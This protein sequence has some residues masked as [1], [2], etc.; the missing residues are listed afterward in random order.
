MYV[1]GIP[2]PSEISEPHER[3]TLGSVLSGTFSSDTHPPGYYILMWAWTRCFGTSLFSIRLPGALFG[4]AC[5]P[6]VYWLGVLLR[7]RAAGWLGAALV[8]FNGDH[9]FFSS[10]ARMYSMTCF[11][12]LLS[13]ALLLRLGQSDHPGP[14]LKFFYVVSV[15]IG[16]SSHIFF[17]TVLVTQTLWV[18]LSALVQKRPLPAVL[19]L[20]VLCWVLGSPLIAFAAL[21]SSSTLAVLSGNVGLFTREYLQF[22][23]LLPHPQVPELD[24]SLIYYFVG[25]DLVSQIYRYLAALAGLALLL[26]AIARQ[27]RA[28]EL[29]TDREGPGARSW[30][31]TAGVAVLAILGFVATFYLKYRVL[32][33]SRIHPTL[34]LIPLP[35]ALAAVALFLSQRWEA[36]GGSLRL[37][38]RFG[39]F[40]TSES[41]VTL[42]AVLPFSLIALGSLGKPLLNQR[43]LIFATPFLLLAVAMPLV[44]IAKRPAVAIAIALLLTALHLASLNSYGKMSNSVCDYQSLAEDLRPRLHRTDVIFLVPR[45]SSTP[46]LYYL[47]ATQYTLVGRDYEKARALHTGARI[48][49]LLFRRQQLSPDMVTALKG[50]RQIGECRALQARAFLYEPAETEP[51]SDSARSRPILSRN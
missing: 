27:P 38:G 51:Q 3:L 18:V 40:G 39:Y 19:R 34:L 24:P 17:W 37:P 41:L 28:E 9:I 36:I 2:L 31:V 6:L 11:F 22:S 10:T 25:T 14:T 45:W 12:A 8:A 33:G 13:A 20:Q 32:R 23:F 47:P 29:L 4:I 5:I 46:I 43:G 26:L 15:L 21:Q 1:P 16:V 44:Q 50:Y 49:V 35:L 48:V 30:M 42:M 7:N